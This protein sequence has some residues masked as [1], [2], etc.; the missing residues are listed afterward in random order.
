MQQGRF[1]DDGDARAISSL[2]CSRSLFGVKQS[3]WCL[4]RRRNSKRLWCVAIG[5]GLRRIPNTSLVP[6]IREVEIG[7]EWNSFRGKICGW[8]QGDELNRRN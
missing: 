6:Q 3:R 4:C 1:V 8:I 7:W 5:K 2:G